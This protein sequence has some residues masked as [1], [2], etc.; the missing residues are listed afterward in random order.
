MRTVVLRVVALALLLL[1]AL[2]GAIAVRT[3]QRLPDMTVYFVRD[4]G[5]SFTLEPTH[6][7]AGRLNPEER[8]RRQVE[9]LVAGPD[10]GS[11]LATTFPPGTTLLSAALSGGVL[12]V[13]LS[14]E[15]EQGGGTALMAGRLNQL[16][17]T[18]TQ[19]ADVDAVRLR[20]G[21][22]EVR[23]FSGDGL[24]VEQPWLRSQQPGLPVW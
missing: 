17:Y 13:D 15:F 7:K 21:G 3:M 4:L 12:T 8:A 5:T 16:F 9:A 18:L 23:V 10:A 20:V 14:R 22:D 19:P 24:E 1:L 2:F 11:G 6:Q